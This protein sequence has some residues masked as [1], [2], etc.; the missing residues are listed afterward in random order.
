MGVIFFGPESPGDILGP[1]AASVWGPYDSIRLPW[2]DG[3]KFRGRSSCRADVIERHLRL[4]AEELVVVDENSLRGSQRKAGQLLHDLGTLAAEGFSDGNSGERSPFVFM[5]ETACS[6]EALLSAARLELDP[7][8]LIGIPAS[9]PTG[10]WPFGDLHDFSSASRLGTYLG[11]ILSPLSGVP[12]SQYMTN[13][14]KQLYNIPRLVKDIESVIYRYEQNHREF[15]VEAVDERRV[16]VF[17]VIYAAGVFAR[18]FR[19]LPFSEEEIRE[20]VKYCENAYF[21][22]YTDIKETNNPVK[23]VAQFLANHYPNFWKVPI[24][25]GKYSSIPEVLGFYTVR[26][27]GSLK[28]ILV[29]PGTFRE[30]FRENALRACDAAG[31]MIRD[32]GTF[33]SKCQ[34][35]PGKK[36][37]HYMYRFKASILELL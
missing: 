15:A 12:I 8:R 10:C 32:S 29:S 4:H 13:F 16:A 3:L 35:C 17:S 24:T 30:H 20:A 1:I 34:L 11:Q 18:I 37:R 36:G 23:A 5:G 19:V 27:D 14:A 31:Y 21:Y 9:A 6:P 7:T 28:E 22:H 33:Q 25:E 2:Q 26:A